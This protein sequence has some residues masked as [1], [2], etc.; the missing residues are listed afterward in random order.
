MPIEK[1]RETL[2]AWF[3]ANDPHFSDW[4]SATTTLSAMLGVDPS[5]VTAAYLHEIFLEVDGEI[6][7]AAG[8]SER[9]DLLLAI[10]ND[11]DVFRATA[12]QVPTFLIVCGHPIEQRDVRQAAWQ[13]LTESAPMV[14]LHVADDWNHNPVLQAPDAIAALIA[15][16]LREQI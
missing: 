11:D 2:G 15:G 3:E 13:R 14:Q 8:A 4:E 9:A 12:V 7:G 5:P 1:G 6:R 10:L 16:W